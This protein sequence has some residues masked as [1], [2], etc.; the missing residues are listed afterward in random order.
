[1][2]IHDSEIEPFIDILK[3]P[4]L[5]NQ[6]GHSPAATRLF[7]PLLTSVDAGKLL[8]LHPVTILRW[9]REGKIPH[10]RLGRKVMFRASELNSWCINGYSISAVRAAA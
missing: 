1:M 8:S 10:L 3:V 2:K 5:G 7:E 4:S 6:L 9:A